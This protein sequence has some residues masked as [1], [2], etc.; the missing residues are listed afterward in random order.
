MVAWSISLK[1]KNCEKGQSAESYWRENVK[2]FFSAQTKKL[3]NFWSVL[4]T[5]I[6]PEG[7]A[8]YKD[9]NAFQWNSLLN[10]CPRRTEQTRWKSR[11][12]LSAIVHLVLSKVECFEAKR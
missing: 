5:T 10:I 2:R 6:L 11:S 9:E 1:V 7:I 12:K 3:G 4:S 8:I